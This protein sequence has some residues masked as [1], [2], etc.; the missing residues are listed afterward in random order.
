MD[1]EELFDPSTVPYLRIEDLGEGLEKRVVREGST[2]I[3]VDVAVIWA[4]KEGRTLSGHSFQKYCHFV[5]KLN[6]KS[7]CVYNPCEHSLFGSMKR[8]EECWALVPPHMHQIGEHSGES[9]WFRL[10]VEEYLED[11]PSTTPSEWTFEERKELA[12]K[13]I[14]IANRLFST[15]KFNYSTPLYNRAVQAMQMKKN[16]L[17]QLAE[18]DKAF[19]EVTSQRCWRNAAV[20][21]LKSSVLSNGEKERLAK[22]SSVISFCKKV[23][24]KIPQDLKALY[25]TAKAHMLREEF[26]KSREIIASCPQPLAEDMTNLLAEIACKEQYN[27]RLAKAKMSTLFNKDVWEAEEA[28]EQEFVQEM[29]RKL[30]LDERIAEKE[31][32]AAKETAAKSAME[33]TVEK[34]QKGF[35]IDLHDP[36]EEGEKLL[37]MM[38]SV[39]DVEEDY[40][41]DRP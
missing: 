22:Y 12:L 11:I 29:D 2:D 25:L 33:A 14:Q 32:K 9:L 39:D 40:G 3:P 17:E 10:F 15:E 37:D 19:I 20:T 23:L 28:K 16:L 21:E 5:Y 6:E 7:T 35:V 34:A 18:E 4:M 1:P 30:R 27:A 26:D 24:E 31:R 38:D 8:G 13:C 36:G 41:W